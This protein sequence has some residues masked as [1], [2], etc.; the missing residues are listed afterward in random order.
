MAVQKSLKLHLNGDGARK[1]PLKK[2]GELIG[3]KDWDNDRFEQSGLVARV[4]PPLHLPGVEDSL[5]SSL[6]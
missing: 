1:W 5:F 3:P 2:V 4:G 6:I